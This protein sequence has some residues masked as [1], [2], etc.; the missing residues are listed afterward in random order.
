[1]QHETGVVI[2]SSS[3][4]SWM[5]GFT[6]VAISRVRWRFT[7]RKKKSNFRIYLIWS[8]YLDVLSINIQRCLPWNLCGCLGVHGK[9][10]KNKKVTI[11]AHLDANEIVRKIWEGIVLIMGK[12]QFDSS[13][14]KHISGLLIGKYKWKIPNDDNSPLMTSTIWSQSTEVK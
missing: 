4:E 6:F 3:E 12:F 10:R 5:E 7:H 8:W 9:D 2:R 11:F 14:R 1:M 13:V